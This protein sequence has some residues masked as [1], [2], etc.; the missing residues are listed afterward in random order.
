M[1]EAA[2][3]AFGHEFFMERMALVAWGIWKQRN[4][5]IFRNLAPSFS[6]WRSCFNDMLKLQMLRFSLILK[7]RISLWLNS[8]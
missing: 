8:R 6:S 7:F 3:N 2:K 1:I 4:D 5:L